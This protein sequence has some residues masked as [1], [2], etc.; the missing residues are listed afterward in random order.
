MPAGIANTPADA[1]AR[2]KAHLW[3]YPPYQYRKEYC[4]RRKD[5]ARLLRPLSANERE[6]LMFL[7]RQSTKF[8]INPTLA[9][10]DPQMLEDARCS[11]VGNG[12]NAGIV[13]LLFA[14]F[15]H[16]RKLLK[17]RPTPQDLIDRMGLLPGDLFTLDL[18]AR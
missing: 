14:P 11:L 7:G 10:K 6:T 1:K 3:R 9:T 13:A 2:W 4:M 5:N 8:A 16:E 17:V 12:F 18:R 15:F